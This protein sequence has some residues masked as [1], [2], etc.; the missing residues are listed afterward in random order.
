M[1]VPAFGGQAGPRLANR[2]RPHTCAI[3]WTIAE[4][5]IG[6]LLYAVKPALPP[7]GP[8]DE[9]IPVHHETPHERTH[10]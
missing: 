3:T 4:V 6:L 10:A 9:S 2:F 5:A 8:H 7:P 1:L